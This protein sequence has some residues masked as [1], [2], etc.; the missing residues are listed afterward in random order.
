[1]LDFKVILVADDESEIRFLKFKMVD[2]VSRYFYLK[3]ISM[4]I[5]LIQITWNALP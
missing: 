4:L 1:M 3:N 2:P 5:K